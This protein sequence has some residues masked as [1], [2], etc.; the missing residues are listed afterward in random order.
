M[1]PAIILAQFLFLFPLLLLQLSANELEENNWHQWRG[2]EKTGASRTAT[3]PL[4]WSESSN[5]SWKVELEGHGTGTPIIWGNRVFLTESLNTNEV[6]PSLPKPEDQPDRVFGIK[7][8]NTSYEMVVSCY[9]RSSGERLWRDVATRL[10][11]H[12][13]HHKD[14]SFASASPFCDGERLY[15]WF[16]SAGLFAYSLDGEK[17]WGRDLGPAKMGASLGE[18][19]SPVVHDGKLVLVRDHSRQSTI[20]CFDAKTGKTLWKKNRDE[21]NT[22]ATPAIAEHEG[23]TQVIT[24]GTNAVRS[25]NLATG[26]LIWKATGLTNNCAPCPIV[27]GPTVYCMTGYKGHSL[28]AIPTTGTGDV[29]DQIRWQANRGTPYVPSAVLYDGQ[30][31][32]TQSNQGIL[33][34]LAAKDGTEV[35]ARTRVPDLGDIYASPVAAQARVYFVGR[36]GTSVVIEAGKEFK[37]LAANQLDDNF[38]ASPALAGKQLFLRG[39]RFLYCLEE[40]ATSQATTKRGTETAPARPGLP[41]DPKTVLSAR[42]KGL[43]DTGKITGQEAI[44]LYLTAFPGERENVTRWL[45]SMKDRNTDKPASTKPETQTAPKPETNTTSTTRE[46]LLKIAKR[47][48]PEDYPGGDGHQP[49]VDKWFASAAP[50]QAGKVSQLWKDQQRLFPNMENRGASFI[51]ILDYVRTEG[52]S[53]K[54][55]VTPA[56]TDKPTEAKATKPNIKRK[57]GARIHREPGNITLGKTGTVAGSVSSQDGKPMGGVMVS[58]FDDSNRQSVSIPLF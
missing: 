38:H 18:G 14:A 6:D 53:P 12:E 26:E 15:C 28:L 27:D 3:P 24:P 1:K 42:L 51:K 19:S 56:Q 54:A 7:F 31:Y 20:E 8:P 41:A 23:T 13:G 55:A 48:I 58:A 11:P 49:F 16:G 44:E 47:E 32:F 4:E 2:P 46:L 10:V 33:T 5:I 22:W 17:L 25:Y 34:S 9:D 37:V 50:E 57:V 45:D 39:M 36:K 21:G 43:V 52:K 40:G 30:L 29:T 35:I